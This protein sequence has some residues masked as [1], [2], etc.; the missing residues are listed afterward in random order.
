MY[1]YRKT[2]VADLESKGINSI[3]H[4]LSIYCSFCQLASLFQSA[5]NK[6]ICLFKRAPCIRNAVSFVQCLSLL[7]WTP[8]STLPID[9]FWIVLAYCQNRSYFQATIRNVNHLYPVDSYIET[10]PFFFYYLFVFC[11][12][13][14]NSSLLSVAF[15]WYCY[16]Q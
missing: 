4:F 13:L 6:K 7:I 12:D 2:H 15:I 10:F 3:I 16:F 5:Q 8:S 11:S 14:C 1:W 9:C